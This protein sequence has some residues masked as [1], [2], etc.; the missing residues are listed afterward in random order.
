[1]ISTHH[2]LPEDLKQA[3]TS[4]DKRLAAVEEEQTRQGTMLTLRS[5]TIPPGRSPF[6]D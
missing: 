4:L 5:I 3:V 1:M 6:K 2:K